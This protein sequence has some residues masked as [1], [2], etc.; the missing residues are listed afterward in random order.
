MSPYVWLAIAAVMAVIE[1][2]SLSLITVW[3]VVGGLVAFV[4][5]FAGGE[6]VVQAIA[7]LVVSLA[8]LLLFRPL[9]L[10]HRAL[11]EANEST[12]V[13]QSA[14]VVE[15]IAASAP[16]RVETPDRMTWVALS[17]TG[18]PLEVG[19]DVR[20]IGQDSIKLIVERI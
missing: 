6:L 12:P 4:V 7:F 15:P 13:G 18:E 14:R 5:G 19:A 2:V 11:G 9:A 17:S 16:G 20:V 10:K 8:C 3:F 1:V